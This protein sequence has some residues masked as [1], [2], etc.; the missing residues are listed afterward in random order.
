MA[1]VTRTVQE[2][3]LIDDYLDYLTAEWA[4]IPALAEEWDSWDG[5]SQ[6]SF[7]VDWP[8]REDRLGM[9]QH[10]AEQGLLTAAQRARYDELQRLVAR[11]RPLLEQLLGEGEGHARED[12]R[13]GDRRTG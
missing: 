9:L 11:Y 10:W 8:I 4:A 12:G 13:D 7:V 1:P 6:L 2:Q 5:L 3:A